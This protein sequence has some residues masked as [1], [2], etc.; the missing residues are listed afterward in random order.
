MRDPNLLPEELRDK[1]EKIKK[2]KIEEEEIKLSSPNKLKNNKDKGGFLNMF[3]FFSPRK[4]MQKVDVKNFQAE[5]K[6]GGSFREKS[7]L[8]ESAPLPRVPVKEM[9]FSIPEQNNEKNSIEISANQE[10]KTQQDSKGIEINLIPEEMRSFVKPTKQIKDLV[11][12]LVGSV[13]VFAMVYA[14]LI[15]YKLN[16]NEQFQNI[17]N[18]IKKI[19]NELVNYSDFKEKDRIVQ[20]RIKLTQKLINNHIYSINV[21]NF[22]EENTIKDITYTNLDY[23]SGWTKNDNGSELTAKIGL[24]GVGKDFESIKNQLLIFQ[25]ATDFVK[26]VEISE[27]LSTTEQKKKKEAKKIEGIGFK[28]EIESQPGVLQYIEKTF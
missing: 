12:V 19:D 16:I 17:Q 2:E 9:E 1:E 4:S 22:L 27:L 20:M 26:K 5:L 14:G 21:L 18:Q 24:E 7:S 10:K 25:N 3:N 8:L 11:K 28:I 23:S 13:V 15:F 6:K